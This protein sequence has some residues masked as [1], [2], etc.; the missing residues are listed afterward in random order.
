MRR[1]FLP[2]PCLRPVRSGTASARVTHRCPPKIYP[3]P[4]LRVGVE[5]CQTIFRSLNCFDGY[6]RFEEHT[7]R[8]YRQLHCGG[9]DR[10]CGGFDRSFAGAGWLRFCICCCCCWCFCCNCCVCCWCR[11]STC[12]FLESS[13]FWAAIFWS[14]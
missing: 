5:S 3:E 4:A 12:C 10:S 7:R 14:S 6:V 9:L 1:R 8:H 13:A 11:C 2:F